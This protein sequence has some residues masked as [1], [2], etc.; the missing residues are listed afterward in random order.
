M[1]KSAKQFSLI[2]E[3]ISALKAVDQN[4]TNPYDSQGTVKRVEGDTA[5]VQLT[6]SSIETPIQKTIDCEIG[7]TVQARVGG[8]SAW[9]TGNLTAP[10]T[11][12][13]KAVKA[14]EMVQNVTKVVQETIDEAID[15]IE[16]PAS[17]DGVT[18]EY[19]LSSSIST[20][21]QVGNWS[22]TP[23]A[24]QSGKYYWTRTVLE[25][26]DGNITYSDPQYSQ[27]TQLTIETKRAYDTTDAHF[28]YDTTGAYVTQN[29]KDA[30][31]GYATRV[32]PSGILQT[33]NGSTLSSWT[34]SGISFYNSSGDALASF[35]AN[36]MQIGKSTQTYVGIYA[37]GSDAGI[38]FKTNGYGLY[39][40]S[41]ADFGINTY[42]GWTDEN[43]PKETWYTLGYRSGTKGYYSFVSGYDNVAAHDAS[44]AFG[45]GNKVHSAAALTVGMQNVIG[46]TSKTSA[47]SHDYT[48][49]GNC[50]S[51]FG[52]GL[53][54]T[55]QNQL[56]AGQYNSANTSAKF[57][58]GG[59]NASSRKNALCVYTN[60]LVD[61]AYGYAVNGKSYLYTTT[62]SSS[63]VTVS[64][65]AHNSGTADAYLSGYTPIGIVGMRRSGTNY[66]YCNIYQYYLS[67]TTI[68]FNARN[69]GSNDAEL[70]VTFTVLYMAN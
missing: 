6:G 35:G 45:I 39:G 54:A 10:P 55:G 70:T 42:T 8:G 1:N 12:D 23:P 41:I 21:V 3:F 36:S 28:W 52:Y 26:E 40:L 47:N 29:D 46:D 25:D 63:E 64:K 30:S 38:K 51:A 69:L 20:F 5:W 44:V 22:S 19:C 49:D 48:V 34:G 18:I 58:V 4:K 31:T 43:W 57:I 67:G 7:D 13:K 14:I 37:T 68:H 11:D 33:Y 60:G 66:G 32:T 53:I 27:T 15:S 62:T 24:Y 59:G 2:K 16:E 9:L 56:V 50:S 17:I 65:G 61:C